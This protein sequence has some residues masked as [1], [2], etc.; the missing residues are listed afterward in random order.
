MTRRTPMKRG[1]SQLSRSAKPIKNSKPKMTAIRKSA[2]NQEC[3][4][5]FPGVCNFDISTTVLCHSNLVA[6]GKGLSI[7]AP[8]TAAAYGCSACHDVLD[9]RRPRPPGLGYELM[10]RLFKDAVDHTHRILK[11]LGLLG[12]IYEQG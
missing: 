9:G 7:K 12:V 11:R 1:I 4:L 8:D 6:D 2:R 5:R 3:T 10:I